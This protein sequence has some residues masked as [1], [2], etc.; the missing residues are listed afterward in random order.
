M[1]PVRDSSHAAALDFELSRSKP[2]AHA[3]QEI[4]ADALV[5]AATAQRT[6]SKGAWLDWETGHVAAQPQAA[7]AHWIEAPGAAYCYSVQ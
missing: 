5:I 7:S 2:R 4:V 3:A 6:C 1:R